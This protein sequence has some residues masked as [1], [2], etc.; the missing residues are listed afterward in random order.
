MFDNKISVMYAV[1][2][3]WIGLLHT[4]SFCEYGLPSLHLL[5]YSGEEFPVAHLRQIASILPHTRIV[6]IY[7]PVETNAITALDVTSQY[8]AM[9]RI[10]IGSPVG[11]SRVFLLGDN[12]E[13]ISR[14]NVDGEI[15]VSGPNVSPGYINDESLTKAS[16]LEISRDGA[17]YECYRTGDFG[18][19]D[20]SGI[21][22]F[23]GRRD[24]RI[25]TRGARVELGEVEACLNANRAVD[26][27][28]VVSRPHEDW[29]NELVAF[30]RMNE[31]APDSALGDLFVWCRARL[32]TYMIPREIFKVDTFPLT[33][34]GKVDRQQLSRAASGEKINSSRLT[35]KAD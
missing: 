11:E 4:E 21:L 17:T 13:L 2:S 26:E 30:V 20:E 27:A 23:H 25:K 3:A 5:M 15:I 24:H 18:S 32:P 22:H 29:T 35:S 28:V 6:N 34:T 12:G 8:L 19:W 1:P 10:P 16:R 14:V 7:G 9:E 33:A 31:T